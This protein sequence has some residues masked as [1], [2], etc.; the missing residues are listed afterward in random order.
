[1]RRIPG[2]YILCSESNNHNRLV[3]HKVPFGKPG[4]GVGKS[5]SGRLNENPAMAVSIAVR[6][7]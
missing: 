3:P 2:F 6:I 4:E 1:M 5:L 7:A